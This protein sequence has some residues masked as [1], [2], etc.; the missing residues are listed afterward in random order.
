MMANYD[1]VEFIATMQRLSVQKFLVNKEIKK[2]IWVISK[3][4][5]F[6]F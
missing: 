6:E 5:G 1:I 3:L 4:K 2:K